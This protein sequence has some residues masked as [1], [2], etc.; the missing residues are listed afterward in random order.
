MFGFLRDSKVICNIRRVSARTPQSCYTF[1]A[2]RNKWAFTVG[3]NPNERVF[4]H[5]LWATEAK[6]TV[7]V[8][9]CSADLEAA[10]LRLPLEHR[11]LPYL[12]HKAHRKTRHVDE[13]GNYTAVINVPPHRVG[14]G[15]AE[16]AFHH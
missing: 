12:L 14:P 7:F 3:A 1:A 9:G 5:A 11:T 4:F 2:A 10:Q 6:L 13:D 8:E 16:P 15:R